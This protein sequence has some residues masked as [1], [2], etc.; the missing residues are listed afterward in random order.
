[1]TGKYKKKGY[2]FEEMWDFEWCENFKT[3]D[4]V[5]NHVR[6]PFPYKR[7]FSTDSLHVKRKTGSL[8]GHVQCD[9]NDPD[10]LK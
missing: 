1:M 10:E 7:L 8:L 4:K 2:K 9:L 5:K 6:T 3:N